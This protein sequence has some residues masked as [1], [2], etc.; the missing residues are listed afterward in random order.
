MFLWIA[1]EHCQAPQ[2]LRVARLGLIEWDGFNGFL[3][4]LMGFGV[5][6]TFGKLVYIICQHT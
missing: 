3:Y 2:C 6:I 4:F 1:Y 5:S